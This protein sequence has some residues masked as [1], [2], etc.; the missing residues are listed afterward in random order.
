M[1]NNIFEDLTAFDAGQVLQSNS[2]N[3][4]ST[5]SLKARI[6]DP[7]WFLA[8]QWQT[9]EFQAENGGKASY[10]ELSW[11]DIKMDN[12]CYAQQQAAGSEV[13]VKEAISPEVLLDAIVEAEDEENTS[14]MWRSEA[15]EYAF[16]LECGQYDLKV[17]EYDG[18]RLDWYSFDMAQKVESRSETRTSYSQRIIASNLYADGFPHPRW[19]RFEDGDVTVYSEEDPEPNVL[20]LLLPEFLNVDVNNW[21]TLPIPQEV[22]Y[23][24]QVTGVK[25]V[26]SFNVVTNVDPAVTDGSENSWGVFTQT[27][28][29]KDTETELSG[30]FMFVPNLGIDHQHGDVLEEVI[31]TR[32]EQANLAWAYEMSY[33]NA[34]GQLLYGGDEPPKI[35]E[36]EDRGKG[37]RFRFMTDMPAYWVPYVPRK[38]TRNAPDGEVC[39]RR[40]RMH[41]S[42]EK[43]YKGQIVSESIIINEEEI[44]RNGIKVKRI[45]RFARD[46]SGKLVSW[47]ARVKENVM[48]PPLPGLQFD[49]I[50][51]T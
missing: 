41:T 51:D 1:A 20:S 44:P 22:G 2:M 24:R 50:L 34:D 13:R 6:H 17:D 33:T 23:M 30:A 47:T 8:R 21:Y 39:F 49:Y 35:I 19:W 36:D 12:V 27:P 18:Q 40:A 32:D 10:I 11:D 28:D 38:L 31:F 48:Q 43:Q 5:E 16:G 37:D 45:R 3:A 42:T 7:L 4:D 14:K 29:P 26:D 9:G 46:G 25:I 15:L